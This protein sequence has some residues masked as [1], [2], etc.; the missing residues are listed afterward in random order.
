MSDALLRAKIAEEEEKKR[1][2]K[3]TVM[4]LF[5]QTKAGCRKDICFN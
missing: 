1:K 5:N 2:V 4:K 3:A